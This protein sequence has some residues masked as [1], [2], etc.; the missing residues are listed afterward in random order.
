MVLL[1][2]KSYWESNYNIIYKVIAI[3]PNKRIFQI[4]GVAYASNFCFAEPVSRFGQRLE[5]QELSLDIVKENTFRETNRLE[6]WSYW[7]CTAP[8]HTMVEVK[9]GLD[10]IFKPMY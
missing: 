1:F 10:S 3:F 4:V 8:S 6:H 2:I 7:D 9:R 5:I